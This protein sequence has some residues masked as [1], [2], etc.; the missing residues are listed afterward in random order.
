[1]FSSQPKKSRSFEA[2]YKEQQPPSVEFLRDGPITVWGT[3]NPEGQPYSFFRPKQEASGVLI[4]GGGSEPGFVLEQVYSAVHRRPVWRLPKSSEGFG[5]ALDRPD[6]LSLSR[7]SA[8]MTTQQMALWRVNALGQFPELPRGCEFVAFSSMNLKVAEIYRQGGLLDAGVYAALFEHAR[9]EGVMPR[10]DRLHKFDDRIA[11]D[12]LTA[13]VKQGRDDQLLYKG[14]G[15][16]LGLMQSQRQNG[17]EFIYACRC[18]G[19]GA[20]V[21]VALLENEK[22]VSLV[23]TMQWRPTEVSELG[24]PKP[25]MAPPISSLVVA[26]AAGLIMDSE[27]E[28]ALVA[29]KDLLSKVVAESLREAEEEIGFMPVPGQ[30]PQLLAVMPSTDFASECH[31]YVLCRGVLSGVGGGVADEGERILRGRVPLTKQGIAE[32]YANINRRGIQ[33]ETPLQVALWLA[34]VDESQRGNAF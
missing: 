17:E 6:L 15:G 23:S 32:F 2:H 31:V 5:A 25:R 8:G 24:D 4:L 21:C 28:A 16:F 11:Q 30:Q 3:V 33:I 14:P 13:M 29:E 1:M 26:P 27:P 19:V 12:A 9:R 10:V 7:P 34:L 22:E 20:V 18:R